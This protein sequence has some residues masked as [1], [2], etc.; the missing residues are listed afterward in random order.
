V[1][2]ALFALGWATTGLAV[3]ILLIGYA[4]GIQ[5]FQISVITLPQI[6]RLDVA[7]VFSIVAMVLTVVVAWTNYRKSRITEQLTKLTDQLSAGRDKMQAV[8]R[9]APQVDPG[10][11]W[12]TFIKFTI[13][14]EKMLRKKAASERLSKGEASTGS[15]RKV[16]E[17]LRMKEVISAPTADSIARIWRLR[18][19]MVHSQMEISREEALAGV[20]LVTAVLSQLTD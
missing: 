6:P 1:G 20:D 8:L 18:N 17:Y 19:M 16:S 4:W 2:V 11:P 10:D 9:R 3:S 12:W 5:I 13:Y 14:L 7:S 15:L